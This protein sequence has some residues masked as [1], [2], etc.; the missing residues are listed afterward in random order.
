MDRKE[1]RP[2]KDQLLYAAGLRSTSARKTVL[3]VL[4]QVKR[5]LSHQEIV[6][7][8]KIGTLDK[9]TLYRTLSTLKRAG[10]L[11]RVQGVDGVWR[12]RAHLS[13]DGKCGGN[14]VHFL[15]TQCNQMMCLPEQP[16]PRVEAP[17]G[18]EVSSKQLVVYGQCAQCVS[19]GEKK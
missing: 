14:H 6:R 7:D 8:P 1:K 19:H 12:F 15:C 4:S 18:A 16:L 13:R 17:K 9:V 5:P 10:L 11:H 3:E 2:S